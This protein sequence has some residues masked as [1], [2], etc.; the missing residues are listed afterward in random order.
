MKKQ[1]RS[2][3]MS[4]LFL[5][6][7]TGT[8][9]TQLVIN[10]L[11]IAP[12]SGDAGAGGEWIELFNGCNATAD[13]S[14][15]VI[16]WVGKSGGGNPEGWTVTIP[17]GTTIASCGYYVIGGSGLTGSCGACWANLGAGGIAWLAGTPNLDLSAS[18]NSALNTIRPGNL[19]NG[20]GEIVLIDP[21]DNII[22][23]VSY[24][25]GNFT[26]STDYPAT[27]N[28]PATCYTA[29]PINA[30]ADGAKNVNATFA[31]ANNHI[32]E[33]RADNNYYASVSFGTPGAAN[34]TQIGCGVSCILPVTWISEGAKGLPDG[35]SVQWETA[36][37]TNC[38][39]FE[40]ELLEGSVFKELTRV[41]GHGTT[42][43]VSSYAVNIEKTFL[44]G[45]S[46]TCYFRVK[47]VDRNGNFEFSPVFS[48]IKDNKLD[49][50]INPTVIYPGNLL[51]VSL[52][53]WVGQEPVL[54]EIISEDGKSVYNQMIYSSSQ[55]ISFQP[56]RS[57]IY[58]C[59]LSSGEQLYIRKFIVR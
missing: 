21:S 1:L 10:E 6:F 15:F 37:E 23:E 13:I 5:V 32:I 41:P 33:L 36:S 47:E 57:G 40:I 42:S 59:K 16:I 50:E 14:C 8:G 45:V 52:K 58:L 43:S 9:Y 12:S 27:A 51:T 48:E 22:S 7:M 11:G 29:N 55:T 53:K 17:A 18:S 2:S 46:E 20:Q 26:S 54:A 35:V 30:I 31:A 44:P 19:V 38:D 34:S 49:F 56:A 3:L 39:H 25:I 4:M 24:N 28:T